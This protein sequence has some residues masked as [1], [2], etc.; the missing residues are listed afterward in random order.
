MK[1]CH[2][3]VLNDVR[4]AEAIRRRE[5]A[6]RLYWELWGE[7]SLVRMAARK[8]IEICVLPIQEI[9]EGDGC[10]MEGLEREEVGVVERNVWL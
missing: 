2:Q 4:S 9:F 7:R 3:S 6:C 10:W 1:R 5:P 8:R